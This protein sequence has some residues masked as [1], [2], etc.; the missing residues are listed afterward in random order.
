MRVHLRSPLWCHHS[1]GKHGVCLRRSGSVRAYWEEVYL[2]SGDLT[3][4]ND[5][6][7]TGGTAFQPNMPPYLSVT[8]DTCIIMS[9]LYRPY[10]ESR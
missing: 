2:V 9:V 3:V 4:G 8:L 6:Q 5:A 7:G 1:A 10:I